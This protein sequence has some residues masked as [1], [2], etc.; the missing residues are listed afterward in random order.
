MRLLVRIKQ[1]LT[2]WCRFVSVLTDICLC[3]YLSKICATTSESEAMNEFVRQLCS[4]DQFG[5]VSALG[6]LFSDRF[7]MG[8]SSTVFSVG[9]IAQGAHTRVVDRYVWI[10][11]VRTQACVISCRTNDP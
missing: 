4:M 2:K 9:V 7:P 8:S 5:R 10:K 1:A 3:F 6:I 11:L